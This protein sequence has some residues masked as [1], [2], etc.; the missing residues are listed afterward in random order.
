MTGC[1]EP[2]ITHMPFQAE[3][4]SPINNVM[5]NRRLLMRLRLDSELIVKIWLPIE[6]VGLYVEG[7]GSQN[8]ECRK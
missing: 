5:G 1:D 2:V 4:M 7:Q 3:K 6:E 8:P